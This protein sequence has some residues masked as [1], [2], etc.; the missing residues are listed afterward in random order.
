MSSSIKR[1]ERKYESNCRNFIGSHVSVVR[2][3]DYHRCGRKC[4]YVFCLIGLAV[5]VLGAFVGGS[6]KKKD[7]GDSS[8]DNNQ[9]N[10]N[11]P[12]N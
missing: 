9:S 1:K 3:Y 7:G 5:T 11:D 4:N 12:K 6:G 2:D 8:N 10:N